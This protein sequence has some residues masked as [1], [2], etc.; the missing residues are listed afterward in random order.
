[1]GYEPAVKLGKDSAT[2]LKAVPGI[3]MPYQDHFAMKK[4]KGW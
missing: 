4:T 2:G 1:M 3:S